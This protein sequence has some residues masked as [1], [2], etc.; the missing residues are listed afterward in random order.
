METAT[1]RAEAMVEDIVSTILKGCR[2][3]VVVDFPMLGQP[4]Y[5]GFIAQFKSSPF[6][7]C[8]QRIYRITL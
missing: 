1:D 8:C 2:L 5:L 6:P 4:R 3:D 7:D